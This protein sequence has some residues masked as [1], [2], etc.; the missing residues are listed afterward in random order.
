MN[1]DEDLLQ[2][3]AAGARIRS[4]HARADSK[5][6]YP[7]DV[8]ILLFRRQLLATLQDMDG[9]MSISELREQLEGDD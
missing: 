2:A 7:S 6:P 1:L 9:S 3:L 8:A 5:D 4:N